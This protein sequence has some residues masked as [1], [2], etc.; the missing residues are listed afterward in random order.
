MMMAMA[1]LDGSFTVTLYL[2]ADGPNGFRTLRTEADVDEFFRREFPDAVPLM[3]TLSTDYFSHPTGSLL[4]VRTHPW[5]VEGK[6]VLLG[7]AA[8]AIVPFY[9]QGANAA[10]EDCLALLE[11]IRR[12]ENLDRAFS[13]YQLER[14]RNADAI[15][16]LAVENFHEMRDH[17]ASPMFLMKK[18]FE[19]L[20]HRFLPFWF[21]PLYPMI[22]F[23]L[24]PYAEAQ[25]RA[26]RQER[27]LK[28]IMMGV[29][30]LLV[31]IVI[32]LVVR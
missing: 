32:F 9:G 20:L 22:S 31:L 16:E 8:H 2:P 6:A 25:A 4:T 7:D 18:R 26:R 13:S 14:K 17:V 1:N 27:A 23:S 5:H 3:P 15:A 30:V 21:M 11:A 29:G 24:I 10:F 12:E 19:K 28:G